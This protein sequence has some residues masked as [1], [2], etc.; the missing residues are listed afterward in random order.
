MPKLEHQ[1]VIDQR[2]QRKMFTSS[3]D[4]TETSRNLKKL[5][6]RSAATQQRAN[7]ER[8]RKEEQAEMNKVPDSEDIEIIDTMDSENNYVRDIDFR[9]NKERLYEDYNMSS[10]PNFAL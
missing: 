1:F 9:L 3:V 7:E 8:R 5:A 2:G 4:P 10:L 6:K